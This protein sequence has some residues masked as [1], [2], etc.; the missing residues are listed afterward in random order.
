M[1]SKQWLFD[2]TFPEL[3]QEIKDP[4]QELNGKQERSYGNNEQY[5]SL[6]N[7]VKA[8]PESPG[9]KIMPRHPGTIPGDN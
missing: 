4:S 2:L 7:L 3:F 6:R 8:G 9:L 5:G 1:Y